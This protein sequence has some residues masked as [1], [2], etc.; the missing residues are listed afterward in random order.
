[1]KTLTEAENVTEET[2]KLMHDIWSNWMR[3]LF[4]KTH[5]TEDS[6]ELIPAGLVDRWKRQAATQYSD[7]TEAEK[8]SDREIARQVFRSLDL[9]H[10]L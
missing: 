6:G 5:Q 7:L 3:Y 4:S 10:L 8:E 1:M 2:A 9:L